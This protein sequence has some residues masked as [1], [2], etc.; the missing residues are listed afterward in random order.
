M[1]KFGEYHKSLPDQPPK[2]QELHPE[3][4]RKMY[5]DPLYRRGEQDRKNKRDDHSRRRRHRDSSSE[6]EVDWTEYV[7]NPDFDMAYQ[8]ADRAYYHQLSSYPSC[9]RII[10]ML[11]F[12]FLQ[13]F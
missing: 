6:D 8:V 3:T 5:S 11:E 10:F 13:I 1:T 7:M 4:R 9:N 12:L 2:N